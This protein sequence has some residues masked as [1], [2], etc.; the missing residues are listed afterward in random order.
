M[1]RVF[2]FYLRYTLDFGCSTK[3]IA[4]VGWDVQN[5]GFL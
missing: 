4:N 2:P 1:H 5:F 3:D